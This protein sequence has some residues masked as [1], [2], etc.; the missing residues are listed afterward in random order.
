MTGADIGKD[1]LM[2]VEIPSLKA[3]AHP[4]KGAGRA[5]SL[6]VTPQTIWL[7][8]DKE[9]DEDRQAEMTLVRQDRKSGVIKE[10]SLPRPGKVHIVGDRIFLSFGNIHE[11]NVGGLVEIDSETGAAHVLVSARRDPPQSPFDNSPGWSAEGVFRG[12]GR[13]LSMLLHQPSGLYELEGGWKR[14]AD[15]LWASVLQYGGQTLLVG[16]RGEAILV[17]PALP[18]PVWWLADKSNAAIVDA[19]W[20]GPAAGIDLRGEAA[21]FREDEL[22][23]VKRD[24]AGRHALLW[25]FRDGPRKG[26]SVP[27]R[28]DFPKDQAARLEPLRQQIGGR[29]VRFEGLLDPN[30]VM[31]PINILATRAGLIL[32]HRDNGFWFIPNADLK[33]WRQNHFPIPKT[34]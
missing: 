19:R 4:F 29:V 15:I 14:M 22:F 8:Y 1:V 7:A 12:P 21:A 18:E 6:T 10:I 31:L 5:S 2:Q 13:A 9:P 11:G 27:L 25:W 3:Q 16:A 30:R 26:I 32:H 24:A 33:E 17:D 23:V 28:F 20:T 34:P